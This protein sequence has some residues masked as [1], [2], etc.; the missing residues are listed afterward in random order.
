MKEFW[1]EIINGV[2]VYETNLISD[3]KT[4]NAINPYSEKMFA[5]YQDAI[6]PLIYAKQL[7][8][9]QEELPH[10]LNQIEYSIYETDY[11]L[12]YFREIIKKSTWS[13]LYSWQLP[14]IS[15]P[16]DPEIMVIPVSNKFINCFTKLFIF[17][18]ETTDNVYISGEDLSFA[19]VDKQ[20][21]TAHEIKNPPYIYYDKYNLFTI[22]NLAAHEKES[23]YLNII[24]LTDLLTK[25]IKAVFTKYSPI[26]H[27]I[28]KSYFILNIHEK[29]TYLAT[30]NKVQTR[31]LK[32]SQ[33]VE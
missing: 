2:E 13:F 22:K 7:M 10:N 12:E 31:L 30:K 16:S 20:K 19:H 32:L 5:G 27:I 18:L 23:F 1:H 6:K 8:Q 29:Q 15:F 11:V 26:E 14:T 21:Q 3:I 17:A 9:S 24:S 28:S 4:I 25:T 33:P